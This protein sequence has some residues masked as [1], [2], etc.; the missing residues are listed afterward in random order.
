MGRG[1]RFCPPFSGLA[2]SSAPS[3]TR[4]CPLPVSATNPLG[5]RHPV[6]PVRPTV[7]SCVLCPV[8]R[9]TKRP[10]GHIN[11]L[12]CSKTRAILVSQHN[13]F[14]VPRLWLRLG[15]EQIASLRRNLQVVS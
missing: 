11:L 14:V 6:A 5:E 1:A 7:P 2:V 8:E 12:R 15:Q 9:L 10:T 3:I 4:T 13:D